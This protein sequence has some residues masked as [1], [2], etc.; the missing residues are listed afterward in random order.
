MEPLHPDRTTG[1]GASTQPI[2]AT[3]CP[4]PEG[5]Q[6]SSPQAS[7]ELTVAQILDISAKDLKARWEM[8]DLIRRSLEEESARLQPRLEELRKRQDDLATKLADITKERKDSDANLEAAMKE[9]EEARKHDTAAAQAVVDNKKIEDRLQPLIDKA[10]EIKKQVED[11]TKAQKEAQEEREA[12]DAARAAATADLQQA[13]TL[14][15]QILTLQDQSWPKCLSDG[16]WNEWRTVLQE[17]AK[18]DASAALVIAA[19]HRFCAAEKAADPQEVSTALQEL[20][21]RLYRFTQDAEQVAKVGAA[22]NETANGRFLLKF[23]RPE[24]PPAE[25]WM[26]Y[27]PG[28]GSVRQVRNWAVYKPGPSGVVQI[29]SKADVQ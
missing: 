3:Q 12:A 17:A 6:T 11:A 2:P 26:N 7:T 24:D 29:A 25:Q 22:L 15:D 20:G 23:A 21:S 4:Q 19:F 27:Q 28:L 14:K 8:L 16:R 13:A 9:R 5:Q 10:A 18:Q 1:I